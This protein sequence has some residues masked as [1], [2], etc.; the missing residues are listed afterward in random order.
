MPKT[1]Q[2]SSY[3]KTLEPHVEKFCQLVAGGATQT[4]AAHQVGK[5]R[6]MAWQ[7]MKQPRVSQRI[8][9]IRDQFNR[10]IIKLRAQKEVREITIDRN[11]II[12]G[13]ADVAGLGDPRKASDS[14]RAVVAALLGLADIFMLRAKNLREVKDFHGWTADELRD[15]AIT[16]TVPERIRLLVGESAGAGIGGTESLRTE[17]I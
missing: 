6:S 11:D 2:K 14:A 4:E 17:K 10:E 1:N 3:L 5:H 8:D 13:L 16:G 12:M 7:W 15:Y 9:E